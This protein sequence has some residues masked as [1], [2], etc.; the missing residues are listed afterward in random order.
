M[1]SVLSPILVVAGL[2]LAGCASAGAPEAGPRGIAVTGIGRVALPP[3]T[4]VIELGVE[5]RKAQLAEATAE[6]DGTM[7]AVLARVKG[8]GVGDADIRT[9]TY[10]IDPVAEP[11][12]SGNASARIVGYQ[13]SNL[14]QVRTRDVGGLGR[15]VDAAV[16]AGANVVRNVHFTLADPARAE[17]EA[18]ALAMQAAAAKARQVAAAA[19]VRLGWLLSVTESPSYQPV[20]RMTLARAP[21]PVEPGQLEVAIS[22]E[23]RYAIDPPASP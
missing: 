5:A 15:I 1:V 3:D 10:S 4:A 2:L 12:P 22:L 18:R 14:V 17:A 19:G 23:A 16:A 6:V 8:V 20:A 13:V 11:R 7:R 9:T 21:G